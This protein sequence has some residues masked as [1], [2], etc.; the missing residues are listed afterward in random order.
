[1]ETNEDFDTRLV[2]EP[3]EGV[4]RFENYRPGGYHPIQIGDHFHGRYRV[5]HE[6]GHGS[7]STAWLA[8]DEQFNN[9]HYMEHTHTQRLLKLH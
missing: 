6:L 2:Y 8:R 1:M 3:L 9:P 7:Y 4:E 5:V